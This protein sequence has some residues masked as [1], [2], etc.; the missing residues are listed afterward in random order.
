MSIGLAAALTGLA[1]WLYLLLFRGMFWRLRE[2]D[3]DAVAPPAHWPS[4]AAVVPA[5]DEAD[6]IAR[7]IGSLLSQDYPGQFRIVLVDDRSSDGT[8]DVARALDAGGRLHIVSG[9]EPPTGWTGKLWAVKQGIAQAR[10]TAPDYLWL[11]DADIAH[12]PDNLRQLVSRAESGRYVLVS[13]M[14]KLRCES[15]AERGLIPAFVF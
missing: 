10:E 4:V 11:T 6:V 3:G 2:R 14:A 8:A 9:A 7:S 1:A 13:L 15:V 12:T 5:R